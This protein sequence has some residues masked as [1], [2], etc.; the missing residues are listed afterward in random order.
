[1]PCVKTLSMSAAAVGELPLQDAVYVPAPVDKIFAVSGVY[2]VKLNATTGAVEASVRISS[3]VN[4][5]ARICYH[6]ATG[7]LYATL[8]NE[9]N[10]G[11]AGLVH[12]NKDIYPINP[13]TMTVGARLDIIT[14][15]GFIINDDFDSAL[16]PAW[17]PRWIASQGN[18]LYFQWNESSF[19]YVVRINPSNFADR[20]T[21][22]G[23]DCQTY[24]SEQLAVGPIYIV[25]P[26]PAN[27]RVEYAP[28]GWNNQN[29]W[30][31]CEIP[32]FWPV[33][34]EYCPINLPT[35]L[36][37]A[38]DGNG[39]LFRIDDLTTDSVTVIPIP[40][41]LGVP[42]PNPCRLRWN[43]YNSLFYLP[44]M[45][46]NAIVLYDPITETWEGYKTGFENPVDCVFTPDGKKFAVQNSPDEP[47]R[48]IT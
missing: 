1:M 34:C 39:N 25:S 24:Q 45:T 6:A 26:D 48:E 47:L 46:D 41:G 7:L 4:G 38:V 19:Y 42:T 27:A 23:D 22:A 44:C 14:N 2:V 18:Y 8:W 29:Q 37:Y 31:D 9:P 20:C 11:D 35:P 16:N 33:A 28:I 21:Q 30:L 40:A 36:Y 13:T 43:T 3:P 32:G 10:L 15:S 17:G 12:P 5:T